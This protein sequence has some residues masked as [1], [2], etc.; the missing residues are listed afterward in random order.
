MGPG[1]NTAVPIGENWYRFVAA[2]PFIGIDEPCIEDGGFVKLREVSVSYTI[3]QP[4][5]SRSIGFSSIDIRVS[6]R[7]LATW[8]NYTGYD[9][10]TNLG[11]AIS[12]NLGAG[13]VDYFNNPQTRAFVFSITLNH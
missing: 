5:V 3:D 12:G 1:A 11:G 7:N 4:W 13:G 2:C 6:G 8:A 9:P 10:E